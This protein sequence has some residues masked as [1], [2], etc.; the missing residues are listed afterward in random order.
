MVI[1][2]QSLL[3]ILVVTGLSYSQKKRSRMKYLSALIFFL[4]CITTFHFIMAYLYCAIKGKPKIGAAFLFVA[5]NSF[6]V[7]YLL[8]IR[9]KKIS[10]I[11]LKLFNYRSRYYPVENSSSTFVRIFIFAMSLAIL[12]VNQIVLFISDSSPHSVNYWAFDLILQGIGKIMILILINI[13]QFISFSFQPFLTLILSIIFYK[14]TEVLNVY[15]RNL[16]HQLREMNKQKILVATEDYFNIQQTILKLHQVLNYPTFFIIVYASN[17]IF[18]SVLLG[19]KSGNRFF[20]DFSIFLDVVTGIAIGVLI[21]IPYT[22]Y[23]SMM[24]EKLFEIKKSVRD[25]LNELARNEKQWTPQC[26]LQSLK[27]IEKDEINYM[28]ACGLFHVSR[29]FILT[30]IGAWLTYDLLI[31]NLL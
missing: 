26:V 12:L 20:S 27:R 18:S 29:G 1:K 11:M 9:R 21:L 2:D 25:K 6:L 30:A 24:T 16:Q 13:S 4:Y 8:Y 14:F 22:I 15:N 31:I 23:S 19:M 3:D 7:Y 5:T 10:S 17:F 28:S